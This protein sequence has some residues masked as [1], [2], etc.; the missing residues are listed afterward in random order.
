[1]D[2][3]AD[4]QMVEAL[5]IPTHLEASGLYKILKHELRRKIL[6]RTSERPWSPSELAEATGEPLKR[7]CEHIDVLRNHKPTVLESVGE[8]PGP[9]G[10]RPQHFYRAVDR[11]VVYAEEWARLPELMQAAFFGDPDHAL[12]RTALHLDQAGRRKVSEIMIEAQER[13]SDVQLESAERSR[14]SGEQLQR[15]ITGFVSFLAALPL[16]Q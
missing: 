11:I 13:L 10:G 8:R 4:A 15:S 12:M 2:G 7:V 14:V 16:K 1:M 3:E 5:K 9:K 6:I